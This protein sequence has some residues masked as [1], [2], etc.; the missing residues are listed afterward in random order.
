MASS[1][2]LPT[3]DMKNDG[4]KSPDSRRS[5]GLDRLLALIERAGN[6]LPHPVVLFAVLFALLAVVSTALDLAGVSAAVPGTDRTEHI[7]GLFTG[8]GLRW[9]LENLVVNFA[10][11]P[12]IATVLTLFMVVGLAERV[13]LLDTLMRAT[14][15]RAPRPY[16]RTRWRS[17]PAR[18]T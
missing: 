13:G 16:C 1:P 4:G 17:P 11:F 3:P 5:G 14:L 15:A 7:T 10:T 12:P 9:L 6:A 2:G 18:R 8:A